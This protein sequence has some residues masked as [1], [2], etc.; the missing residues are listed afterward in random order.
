MGSRLVG[1]RR[2]GSDRWEW[3]WIEEP[4]QRPTRPRPWK[5]ALPLALVALLLSLWL[6]GSLN[7][8]QAIRWSSPGDEAPAGGVQLSQDAAPLSGAIFTTLEDGSRVNHNIYDHKCD[9]YLDG[10]PGPNAPKDAAGL[11]D[12]HYYFQVTDPSGKKLLSLDKVKFRQFEV[13]DGIIVG[14]SGDGNHDTGVDIDHGA[15]TIQLCPYKNTPNRGG[16]YKVW[17]TPVGS[18]AGDPNKVDDRRAAAFHGFLPAASKTDNFKVKPRVVPPTIEVR[19]FH[20]TNADGDWDA[21][22]EEIRSWKVT[23]KDPLGVTNNY[24]TPVTVD[25]PVKGN[26]EVCEELP[27]G[28]LQTASYLDEA[29]IVPPIDCVIV[30]VAGSEGETH[31]VLFGN[32]QLGEITA[33][34]FYDSNHNGIDD[35][36]IDIPGWKIILSGTAV[37]GEPVGPIVAFTGNDGCTTFDDLL[38]GSY[39]VEE[40]LPNAEWIPTTPTSVLVELEEGA[41][42]TVKFG[43]YCLFPG[44]LTWGYW[45]THSALGPAGPRDPTYDTLPS[46]PIEMDDPIV[47]ASDVDAV[48]VFEGAGDFPANCSGDCRSLLR[49]QLLALL[50]NLRKFDGMADAYYANPSDPVW[51]DGTHTAGE[52]ADAAL[53]LLVGGP[54]DYDFTSFQETLDAINNNATTQVLVPSEPCPFV[55]PY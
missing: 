29:P 19:K 52:I 39:I 26:Y 6:S 8:G 54:P 10:G 43:N 21:G 51:G 25:A 45:K 20:D 30:P 28:W 12:G 55:T 3:Q 7:T 11:P 23:I 49:A 32:I 16:V 27:D 31:T 5:I 15:V 2:A 4:E 48:F 34:K 1:W 18:F 50:L 44:G 47:V 37:N 17:V 24:H 9:V 14:L 41:S 36:G 33:C 22:E 38:P 42:E 35:D 13:E 40:V 53:E 46:D